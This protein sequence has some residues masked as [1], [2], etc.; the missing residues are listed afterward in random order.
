M[1]RRLLHPSDSFMRAMY[2]HQ[3]FTGL[4]KHFPNK[5]NQAPCTICYT[6]K[7]TTFPKLTT[8]DTTNLQSGYF[9]H[10]YFTFYNVTSVHGFASILTVL[11]SKT[12]FFW[13][14]PNVLKKSPV[15]IISFILTTWKI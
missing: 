9:I 10:L 8:V 13:V 14:F 6:E 3:T 15:R 7:V 11:C 12:G 4:P 2:H 1:H 5:L